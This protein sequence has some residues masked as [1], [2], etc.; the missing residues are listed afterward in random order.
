M[1]NELLNS[2]SKVGN[3]IYF[4]FDQWFCLSFNSNTHSSELSGT[5][6][7]APIISSAIQFYLFFCLYFNTIT[8]H[9]LS[10][11]AFFYQEPVAEHPRM[12][13]VW[14]ILVCRCV[15][16]FA[17]IQLNDWIAEIKDVLPCS[18]YLD[19]LRY[20]GWCEA[21]VFKYVKTKWVNVVT[22]EFNYLQFTRLSAFR[23]ADTE[24]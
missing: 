7:S 10:H 2:W 18:S 14:S 8:R 24:V 3:S 23:N 1:S 22:T 9:H 13:C 21:D 15:V 20:S 5:N 16:S 4:E 17:S 19:A 6:Q 11:C 12:N